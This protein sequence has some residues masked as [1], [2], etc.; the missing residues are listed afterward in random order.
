MVLVNKDIPIP[1][2]VLMEWK[3]VKIIICSYAALEWLENKINISLLKSQEDLT[4]SK[5]SANCG[6]GSEKK[7]FKKQKHYQNDS[8]N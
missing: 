4:K 1:E 7:H 2:S 6:D 5:C 3:C 8:F